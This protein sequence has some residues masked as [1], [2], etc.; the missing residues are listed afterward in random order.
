M[1]IQKWHVYL[2]NLNP[3]FGT[4]AGKLRPVVV[5]QT[6]FLNLENHPSTIVCPITSR[7]V[8]DAFPLRV[9]LKPGEAGLHAASDIMVDQIRAIDNSRIKKHLGILE[10]ESM[11]ALHQQLKII[12]DL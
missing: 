7:S 12:L 5:I 9:P 11:K 4:E 3:R 1:Q 6:E 2:A 10:R 8:L